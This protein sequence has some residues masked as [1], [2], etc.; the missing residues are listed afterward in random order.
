MKKKYIIKGALDNSILRL[1]SSGAYEGIYS[2]GYVSDIYSRLKDIMLFDSR[3]EA[4][5][6]IKEDRVMPKG[7]SVTIVEIF[8]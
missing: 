4:E 2:M 5:K 6:Y 8:L 7:H 3:E 1:N